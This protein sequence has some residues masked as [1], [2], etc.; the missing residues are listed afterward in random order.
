MFE[1]GTAKEHQDAEH[2]SET[3]LALGMVLVM[4]VRARHCP[5]AL[6]SGQTSGFRLAGLSGSTAP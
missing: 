2:V 1:L 4:Q 5:L 6:N 3:I